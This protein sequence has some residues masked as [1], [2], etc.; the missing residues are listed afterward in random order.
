MNLIEARAELELLTVNRTNSDLRCQA[1]RELVADAMRNKQEATA[2]AL[3]GRL[4]QETN[5]IFADHI[6]QLDV[7]RQTQDAGFNSALADCR[8]EAGSDP[9]KI[10]ELATWQMAKT[11]PGDALAW[12][13]SLPLNTRTNQ[14]VEL[15]TAECFITLH[16]WPGLEAS[17]QKQNWAELEFIRHAFL[18]RALRG[19]ELADSA[20]VEWKQAL[21]TANGQK[22]SLFMLRNLAA[23]W[24][25]LNEDEELLSIIVD[26]YPD[27]HGARRALLQALYAGGRTRSLM[28]FFNQEVKRNPSDPAAKN[29]LAV[30]ALL[31]NASGV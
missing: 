11:S 30:T 19:Q 23:Q 22:Q 12:L 28:Q 3:C 18:S 16:D 17:V 31:L 6:L 25:W 20:Q 15:L 5:A 14:A 1:L 13:Q 10:Y 24:N 2:L 21:Q 26:R 9:G 27:E 4:L 7:L 29:N 8:H